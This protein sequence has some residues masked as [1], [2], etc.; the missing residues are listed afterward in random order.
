[1]PVPPIC[2]ADV[3]RL[4]GRIFRRAKQQT[5]CF[6]TLAPSLVTRCSGFCLDV[7]FYHQ[8]LGKPLEALTQ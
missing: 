5:F 3:P 4:Q 6:L 1:M 8:V 2:P 7:D